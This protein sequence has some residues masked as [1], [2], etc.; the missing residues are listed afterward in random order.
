MV[1]RGALPW[2]RGFQIG[3]T[4]DVLLTFLESGDYRGPLKEAK[5]GPLRS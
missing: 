5:G 4:I 2:P 1:L 3:A